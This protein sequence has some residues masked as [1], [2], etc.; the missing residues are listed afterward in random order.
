MLPFVCPVGAERWAAKYGKGAKKHQLHLHFLMTA[1][2][3]VPVD[4]F[5]NSDSRLEES[6]VITLKI[7]QKKHRLT[8]IVVLCLTA[9]DY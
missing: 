1:I 4:R 6:F 3:C 7:I 9:A 5:I 8:R 2:R